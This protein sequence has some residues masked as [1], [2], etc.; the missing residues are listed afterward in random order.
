[1]SKVDTT[2]RSYR[3]IELSDLKRLI[4]IAQKDQIEFFEKYPEWAKL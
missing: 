2:G 4:Q 3:V 1:M